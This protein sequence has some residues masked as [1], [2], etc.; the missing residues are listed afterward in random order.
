MKKK[1]IGIQSCCATNNVVQELSGQIL[2]Y[3]EEKFNSIG[4]DE[5][6]AAQAAATQAVFNNLRQE[7]VKLFS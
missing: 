5:V 1:R 7:V 2:V 6:E 3:D 4:E